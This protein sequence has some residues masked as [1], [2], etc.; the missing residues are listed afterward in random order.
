[1]FQGETG[2]ALLCP[3]NLLGHFGIDE[4]NMAFTIFIRF[5]E[6]YFVRWAPTR[7]SSNETMAVRFYSDTAN[8][9]ARISMLVPLQEHNDDEKA[10]VE[11]VP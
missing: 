2:P 10:R 9:R 8:S 6:A 1:M 11:A 7:V 3:G 5:E 4:L